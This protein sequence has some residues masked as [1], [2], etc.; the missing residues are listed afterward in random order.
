[1]LNRCYPLG[2]LCLEG[3]NEAIVGNSVDNGCSNGICCY[4]RDFGGRC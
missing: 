3:N 1:M 2:K 4:I